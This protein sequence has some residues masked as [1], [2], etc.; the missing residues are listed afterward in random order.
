VG[1]A[2]NTEAMGR[3]WYDEAKGRAIVKI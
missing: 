3:A 1:A 2:L